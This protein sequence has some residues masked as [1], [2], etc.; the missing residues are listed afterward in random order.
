[1]EN[2]F[3]DNW[4]GI[5]RTFFITVMAYVSMILFLR[6]SGK[7]TLTK[8][9]AF[10]FIIT[11]ALGSALATIALNKNV[12]LAEGALV[13]F[14]F[15]FLQYS[16]TWISVRVKAVKQIITSEPVLLLYK[17]ELFDQVRIS[18]RIT[19]EEIYF[20]ARSKGIAALQ[21]IDIIILETTGDITVIPRFQGAGTETLEDVKRPDIMPGISDG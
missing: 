11:V 2:I 4:E 19:M 1:M 21:D 3:F 20:A 9:N 14:L 15:I 8:M 6:F 16:I 18:E 17:G 10:D 12:P 5:V 13:F 7:R